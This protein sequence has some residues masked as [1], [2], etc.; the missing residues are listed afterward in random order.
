M[1]SRANS[2]KVISAAEYSRKYLDPR[3]VQPIFQGMIL[4]FLKLSLKFTIFVLA[5]HIIYLTRIGIKYDC[6][7]YNPP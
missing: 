6:E 4:G 2:R 3:L 7:Q 5:L 1:S